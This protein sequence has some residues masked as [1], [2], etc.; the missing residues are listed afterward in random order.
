MIYTQ[1]LARPDIRV[2]SP[3]NRL[4]KDAFERKVAEGNVAR[5]SVAEGNVLER[6]V[7]GSEGVGTHGTECRATLRQVA[8]LILA[9]N[10]PKSRFLDSV[11]IVANS[12]TTLVLLRPKPIGENSSMGSSRRNRPLVLLAFKLRRLS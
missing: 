10:A 6:S 11:G 9:G 8:G 3:L 12:T 1:V 4:E 2:I 5:K 7:L